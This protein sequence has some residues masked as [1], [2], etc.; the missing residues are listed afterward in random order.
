MGIW[1]QDQVVIEAAFSSMISTETSAKPHKK[2]KEWKKTKDPSWDLPN[3]GYLL[4]QKQ[5]KLHLI[6][7][8]WAKNEQQQKAFHP[9]EKETEREGKKT[10]SQ[11]PEAYLQGLDFLWPKNF[12]KTKSQKLLRVFWYKSCHEEWNVILADSDRPQ[13]AFLFVAWVVQQNFRS[14]DK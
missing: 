2:S 3:L 10:L 5:E 13:A 8:W 12:Q 9:K 14:K 11:V 4:V 7:A 1:D 6:I